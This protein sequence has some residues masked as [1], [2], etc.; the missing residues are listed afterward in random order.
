MFRAVD[1]GTVIFRL[2]VLSI[3]FSY[4]HFVRV[5]VCRMTDDSKIILRWEIDNAAARF[6]TGKV[7]SE[8]FDKGGFKWLVHISC[9]EKIINLK[10]SR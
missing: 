4:H 6:A 7:E 5:F 10:Y 2:N 1:G 9:W 3:F 8:V